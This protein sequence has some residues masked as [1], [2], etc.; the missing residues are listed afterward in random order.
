MCNKGFDG[1]ICTK[2]CFGKDLCY[3]PKDEYRARLMNKT[4]TECPLKDIPVYLRAE[5]FRSA[6]I[7]SVVVTNGIKD[8]SKLI[9]ETYKDTYY[10]GKEDIHRA[11]KISGTDDIIN[12]VFILNTLIESASGKEVLLDSVFEDIPFSFM[13]SILDQFLKWASIC[14]VKG[15]VLATD[16]VTTCDLNALSPMMSEKCRWMTVENAQELTVPDFIRNQARVPMSGGAID[17][18]SM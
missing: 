6:Y 10:I 1:Y 3:L 17:G 13:V 9:R 5:E 8:S 11:P 18:K 2:K 15:I 12:R 4:I 14:G 7:T 16:K